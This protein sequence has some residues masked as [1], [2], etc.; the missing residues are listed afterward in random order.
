MRLCISGARFAKARMGQD[1]FDDPVLS[2]PRR[3][4]CPARLFRQEAMS[5]RREQAAGNLIYATLPVCRQR[6]PLLQAMAD[7][8][9]PTISPATASVNTTH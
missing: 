9:Q 1:L 3:H 2:P 8:K 7:G 5:G 6:P 4:R